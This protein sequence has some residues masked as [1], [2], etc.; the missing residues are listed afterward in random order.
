MPATAMMAECHWNMFRSQVF[1]GF[2]LFL[3]RVQKVY[4]CP[5]LPLP[6]FWDI[7]AL[8]N[9]VVWFALQEWH[10]QAGN[11]HV[12]MS[13][14][15]CCFQQVA[16]ANSSLHTF[17]QE[18][19]V[20]LPSGILPSFVFHW[21]NSCGM[22]REVTPSF[23]VMFPVQWSNQ[24]ATATWTNISKLDLQSSFI[25]RVS[26]HFLVIV[27]MPQRQLPLAGEWIPKH[28]VATLMFTLG[29]TQ[30]PCIWSPSTAWNEF[31]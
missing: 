19:W 12:E 15:H 8:W 18:D 30:L 22:E 10:T 28:W 9:V 26:S 11:Y 25:L 5:L 23:L 31:W 16:R 29:N 3:T 4:L 21:N 17:K 6:V 27:I 20:L 14:C 24:G 1:V 13:S 7:V 2:F